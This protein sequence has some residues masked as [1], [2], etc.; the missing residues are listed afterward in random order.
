[1]HNLHTGP[2]LWRP[3]PIWPDTDIHTYSRIRE[4]EIRVLECPQSGTTQVQ[5]RVVELLRRCHAHSTTVFPPASTLSLPIR[6][7]SILTF[8][9]F[10]DNQRWTLCTTSAMHLFINWISFIQGKSRRRGR[11]GGYKTHILES[12]TSDLTRGDKNTFSFLFLLF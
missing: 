4:Q 7:N 6:L 10:I 5:T 8:K 3:S 12:L 11:N 9:E 1:M 2:R